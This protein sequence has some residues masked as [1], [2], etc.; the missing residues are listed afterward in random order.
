MYQLLDILFDIFVMP[1]LV[2]GL[3]ESIVQAMAS[4]V[5]VIA[6]NIN[7]NKEVVVHN[8]TGLL[9]QSSNSD[10]LE[11]EILRIIN[12]E[13]DVKFMVD[14]A[15]VFIEKNLDINDITNKYIELYKE[16]IR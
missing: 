13:V 4:K 8:R 5:P 7:P 6:S 12:K 14:N 1:S 3:S 11:Y 2:E 15:R 16:Y 10:S 9:F